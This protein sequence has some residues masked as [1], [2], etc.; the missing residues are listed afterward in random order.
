MTTVT[1]GTDFNKLIGNPNN[2]FQLFLAT[3]KGVYRSDTAGYNWY[4]WSEGLRLDEEV[5]DIVINTHNVGQISL[6]IG[7]KGRGFWQRLL[8]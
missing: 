6:Y 7:T 8:E 2:V 3:S 5:Q 1:S 4:L